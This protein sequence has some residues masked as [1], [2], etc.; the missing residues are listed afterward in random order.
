[1]QAGKVGDRYSGKEDNNETKGYGH[2]MGCRNGWQAM[3]LGVQAV[4]R[5]P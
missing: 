4:V 2:G 3:V 5:S 1:M